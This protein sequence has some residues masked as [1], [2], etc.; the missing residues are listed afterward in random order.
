MNSMKAVR[1]HAYGGPVVLFHE[2]APRPEAGDGEVLVRVAAAGVNPIDCKVRAGQ[3]RQLLPLTM[4]WT[5]GLDLSGTVEALG[6]NRTD[7]KVGT[8]VFGRADLPRAG[9]YA[10]YVA[11]TAA[12]LVPKPAAIAHE[13]AAAVPLAALTAW[14]AIVPKGSLEIRPD[15]TLLILG[16]AGGVG[17]MAVQIAR[18]RGARVIAAARGSQAAYLRELGVDK[19]VDSADLQKAG[20]VDAVLDLVDGEVAERAWKQVRRGGAFASIVAPPSTDEAAAREARIVRTSTQ[21][22]EA[23]LAEIAELVASGILEVNVTKTFP[24][25]RAADAHAALE[26]PYAHGKLVLTTR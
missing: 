9:A 24:L 4:P 17:S 21:T 18:W 8:E 19:V 26:A 13:Y 25:K 11:V 6:S 22:S 15:Q 5:P 14:Q 3:L 10:E 16:A 12:N 20:E 2:D 1:I 23:H 7:L